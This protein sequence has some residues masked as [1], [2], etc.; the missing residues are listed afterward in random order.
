MKFAF[1]AAKQVAFPVVVMCRVLGVSKSGYYASAKRAPSARS[2]ADGR[3]AVE[4]TAAHRRSRRRYGSPRVHR[5]LRKK[6][7]RVGRKRIERLMREKGLVGRQKRRFRRTTDSKHTSPI[8]P[9]VLARDFE[10]KAPNQAWAGDVTYIATD[11]GWAYLA[12]LLDLFSRRVVGWAISA[13]NDTELALAA[14]RRAVATRHRVPS[15][16]VH[17]T[18]RG[19]PYA[20]DD[21]RGALA[22]HAMTASMSRTGDCWDNAVAESFFATLR[23]ELVDDEHYATRRHAEASIGEYIERFYNAERLHSHLDYVSPIEFELKSRIAAVAA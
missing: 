14:L 6:G 18:D 16:I 9:N 2:Q 11:Q 15:G 21:Y 19:S 10:P 1:I 17:H 8:A 4:I 12:V 7:L 13:T 3:L 22:E 23:A 5:A 20:S